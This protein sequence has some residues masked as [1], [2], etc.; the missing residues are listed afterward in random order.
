MGIEEL[1]N[2]LISIGFTMSNPGIFYLHEYISVELENIYPYD[3]I[4]VNFYFGKINLYAVVPL[5]KLNFN[6]LYSEL[7]TFLRNDER[8]TKWVKIEAR[9]NK[10]NDILNK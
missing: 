9:N 4:M 5:E 7:N 3:N 6:R 2:H 8:L 1:H 10:L